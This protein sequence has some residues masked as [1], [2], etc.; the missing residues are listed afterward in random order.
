MRSFCTPG[1]TVIIYQS[2]ETEQA[3]DR[4]NTCQDTCQLSLNFIIFIHM[5]HRT[6][7][8]VL[9]KKT[10]AGSLSL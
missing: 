4:I 9:G 6:W 5:Q 7:S 10:Y 1:F 8:G 3:K 2:K